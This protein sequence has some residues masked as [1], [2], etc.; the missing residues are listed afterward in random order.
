MWYFYIYYCERLVYMR[1]CEK[2]GFVMDEFSYWRDEQNCLICSWV[3]SED[4]MTALKYAELSETEKDA[5]DKQL[6]NLIKSSSKFSESSHNIVQQRMERGGGGLEL[7]NI[8]Y[9][10]MK[11]AMQKMY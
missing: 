4:D 2:F 11:N 7:K 6:I 10:S 9:S 1:Y 5:Y 3:W 8:C